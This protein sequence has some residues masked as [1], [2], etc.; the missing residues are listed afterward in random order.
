[1]QRGLFILLVT[2]LVTSI[3]LIMFSLFILKILKDHFNLE[4][5]DGWLMII[6]TNDRT[7]T[8]LTS[9]TAII[10]RNRS[11]YYHETIHKDRTT[12]IQTKEDLSIIRNLTKLLI[13]FTHLLLPLLT[14]NLKCMQVCLID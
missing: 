2:I 3:L 8:A 7:K 1:M 12:Q 14:Q 4:N 9:N 6:E 13:Y 5:K 11:A 10:I